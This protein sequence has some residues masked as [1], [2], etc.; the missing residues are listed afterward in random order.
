MAYVIVPPVPAGLGLAV[1][2]TVM[3]AGSTGGAAG[4]AA[5]ARGAAA[6]GDAARAAPASRTP[7]HACRRIGPDGSAGPKQR[8]NGDVAWL[9]RDGWRVVDVD[10][11]E[12]E[13]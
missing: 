10:A 12:N 2:A 3:S 1:P 6:S 8:R 9:P 5:A 11:L 13:W 4:G 7:N